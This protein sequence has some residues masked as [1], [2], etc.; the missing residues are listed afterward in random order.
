MEIVYGALFVLCGVG[1][2]L[3]LIGGTKLMVRDHTFSGV[4]MFLS[5]AVVFYL[6]IQT[7]E[8]F[9]G[10]VC[11]KSEQSAEFV[12]AEGTTDEAESDST[13]TY[14]LTVSESG[15]VLSLKKLF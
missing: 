7:E 1:C 12:M 15:E 9:I 5:T 3:T 13:S 4:L 6:A 14:I 2:A 11:A 10:A 8:L